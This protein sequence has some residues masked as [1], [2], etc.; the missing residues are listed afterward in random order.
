MNE[1][2]R[3]LLWWLFRSELKRNRLP[4]CQVLAEHFL[5]I[6]LAWSDRG[7]VI[8][9]IQHSLSRQW[10]ETIKWFVIQTFP[11]SLFCRG[12]TVTLFSGFGGKD[13]RR[14]Q[15]SWE[16]CA[17][18]SLACSNGGIRF[19]T[20]SPLLPSS[21]ES[22]EVQ[23]FQAALISALYFILISFV[24]KYICIRSMM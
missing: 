21:P 5:V 13:E 17:V 14:C 23:R 12:L 6:W 7:K 16:G 19:L 9:Y 3:G 24:I 2:Y 11:H 20:W 15:E 22:T 18:V 10:G 1:M 4:S 8:I